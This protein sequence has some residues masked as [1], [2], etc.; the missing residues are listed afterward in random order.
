MGWRESGSKWKG[1]GC[2]APNMTVD[3]SSSVV[4]QLSGESWI[5]ASMRL[6]GP[7]HST[8][9]AQ[10]VKSCAWLFHLCSQS[11]DAAISEVVRPFVAQSYSIGIARNRR[12]P[13]EFSRPRPRP[14]RRPRNRKWKS[15]T[16]RGQFGAARRSLPYR[17]FGI[18]GSWAHSTSPSER[19]A[20]AI[21]RYDRLICATAFACSLRG[22]V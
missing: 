12:T 15:R 18:G 22:R 1:L 10:C 7:D 17:G 20:D 6:H 5:P 11:S 19:L 4:R 16:A 13:R 8:T 2:R 14:R 9:T 3:S 21:L